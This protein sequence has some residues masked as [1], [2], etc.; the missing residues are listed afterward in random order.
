MKIIPLFS[1]QY[2]KN[3]SLAKAEGQ[4]CAHVYGSVAPTPSLSPN[5]APASDPGSA[6]AQV[7]AHI[8]FSF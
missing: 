2:G 8:F 7:S 5:P 4:M 6:P 1:K 3:K